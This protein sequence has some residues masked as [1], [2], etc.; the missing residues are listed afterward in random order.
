ML[1]SAHKIGGRGFS[2]AIWASGLMTIVGMTSLWVISDADALARIVGS[3][4]LAMGG[5]GAAYQAQN[6]AQGLPG[7]RDYRGQY[8]GHGQTRRIT[9]PEEE[10]K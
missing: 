2:V 1:S 9:D 8:R 5:I 6:F 4:M 3:Y 7:V 10:E